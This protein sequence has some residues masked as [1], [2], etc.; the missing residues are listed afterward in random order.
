MRSYVYRN[1]ESCS[2]GT[3]HRRETREPI[4]VDLNERP[5]NNY[6][7]RQVMPLTPVSYD[8]MSVYDTVSMANAHQHIFE[9]VRFT[10]MIWLEE[11]FSDDEISLGYYEVFN[12]YFYVPR[13]MELSNIELCEQGHSIYD[14]DT[15]PL[16]SRMGGEEYYRWRISQLEDRLGE[17]EEQRTI[18]PREQIND[19][20]AGRAE[21]NGKPIPAEYFENDIFELE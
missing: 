19:I 6:H 1:H 15:T 12:S 2:V 20:H 13:K 4:V 16:A 3:Q 21:V 10:S 17:L 18:L 14:R 8:T 9:T 7:E 11:S 5:D